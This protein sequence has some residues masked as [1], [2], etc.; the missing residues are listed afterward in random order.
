[1]DMARFRL[2]KKLMIPIILLVL[3][4]FIVYKI[5]TY[6]EKYK[7]APQMCANEPKKKTWST[8]LNDFVIDTSIT[9]KEMRDTFEADAHSV[10][11]FDNKKCPSWWYKHH[12]KFPKCGD[13]PKGCETYDPAWKDQ[14]GLSHKNNHKNCKYHFDW[15]LGLMADDVCSECGKC[16]PLVAQNR[17]IAPPTIP[18]P[19]PFVLYA[20]DA[21][22]IP[23][24][25]KNE[26]NLGNFESVE[27][28]HSACVTQAES[29]NPPETCKYFIF[30]TGNKKGQCWWE[31][32]CNRFESDEYNVYTTVLNNQNCKKSTK[33]TEYRGSENKTQSGLKCLNWTQQ[34]KSARGIGW[35]TGYPNAKLKGIEDHNYCRNPDN[36]P[37]GPWCYTTDPNVRWEYCDI[38]YCKNKE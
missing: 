26:V 8:S 18:P 1:M 25:R 21:E 17:R 20:K 36:E 2:N 4:I 38:S 7:D 32:T 35:H 33:G 30:G 22:C 16:I 10:S 19:P 13:M 9:N 23:N 37:N 34:V 3:I 14:H 6:S 11:E 15:K 12:R 24:G 31:K 29:M 28:C 5:N 27:Q